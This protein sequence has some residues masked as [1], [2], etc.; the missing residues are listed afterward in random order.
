MVDGRGYIGSEKSRRGR[1]AGAW[2]VLDARA[3]ETEGVTEVE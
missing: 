1:G 3:G 2:L